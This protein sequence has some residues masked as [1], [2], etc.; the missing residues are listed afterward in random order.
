MQKQT[1]VLAAGALLLL[2]AGAMLAPQ[3]LAED[4]V[5][6]VRW[7]AKD[8]VEV[9]V[10]TLTDAETGNVVS[11]DGIERI[12]AEGE[13]GALSDEARVALIL[14]GRVVNKFQAPVA[15]ATVWLDFGRGGARGGG[16]GNR[17]R[18]VP[19]PVQSD[20]EGRFA[21]Q[22]QT[23]RNLRVSL[24][25]GHGNYAPGLFDKDLGEVTAEV[26][27]GDL[28]LT[29]GGEVIG[30]VTDLEGNGI[31]NA[32][33]DFGPDGGNR[34]GMVRNRENLMPKIVTDN[35]GFYRK[36]H[37][38]A[39]E[40]TASATAKR[41]T[42]GRAPTFVV[43]EDQVVAV[44]DIRLGP[45][46]EVTGYVRTTQGQPIAKAEVT[47]RSINRGGR[48]RG[49]G[50]E[51]GTPGLNAPGTNGQNWGPENWRAM[52]GR[53]Y[54]TETDEQGRFFLEHLPSVPLQIEAR[55]DG[56]LDFDQQPIDPTLGQP[57]NV[58]MQDGLRIAGTVVDAIDNQPVSLFAVRATRVRGL[59]VAGQA[60]LD[61][62]IQDLMTRLRDGNLDEATRGQLRQQVE[63][64]RATANVEF[65]RGGRGDRGG[66]GGPGGRGGNDNNGPGGGRGP[67]RDLGKPEKHPGGTFVVT[68]LQEGVYEVSV[69]SPEHARFRSQEVEV[70]L[71]LSPPTVAANLD[72]GLFVAGVVTSEKGTPVQGATVELRASSFE[73]A[74]GRRGGRGGRGGNEGEA[75]RAVGPPTS[76]GNAT[77]QGFREFQRFAAGTLVTIEATTDADGVFVLKH[78]ARGSYRLQARARGFADASSDTFDLQADRSGVALQLGLLGSVTGKVR[79]LR[80]KETSEAHVAA[81]QISGGQGGFGGMFRGRGGPGGGGP[82]NSV[83][84]QADGTY[85]IDDLAPGDYIVRSWIGGAQDL[86]REMMPQFF[87]NTLTA[88]VK[89]KG[90]EVANFDLTVFRP[91]IGEVAGTVMHNGTAAV[92]FRVE[93]TLVDENGGA[94]QG[95]GGRGGGPGGGRQGG[96]FGGG[97]SFQATVASSGNFAIKDVPAGSYRLRVQPA[98]R[99]GTLHEEMVHVAADATTELNLRVDTASLRGTVT[100][101]DGAN[102]SELNGSVMLLA[103]L[104]AMPENLQA[105]RRDPNNTTFDARVQNGGF[106]FETL[107]PDNY[108]L[109]LT[110]RGRERTSLPVVVVAGSEQPVVVAAGKVA[111]PASGGNAPQSGQPARPNGSTGR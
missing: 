2:S 68:G 78:A 79:G 88:D 13:G 44:E 87:A 107:K 81:M 14:R 92:G 15:D 43:E 74:P 39:G 62:S 64:L 90:G 65:G 3:W 47:M 19:D 75:V 20:K 70:R 41:H 27:L 7:D 69:Q 84:V 80:S 46:F 95:R 54:S 35:N 24:Q 109:V 31:A 104:T 11:A 52:F 48:G 76:A 93:L 72:R 9:D 105:W 29:N 82:F 77:E 55:A 58:V 33:I 101:D 8:E 102:A 17:Q 89:V 97:R 37:V 83:T 73:Q 67:A 30:R 23:F 99:G 50:G 86:M 51:A 26:D 96:P 18:R 45:G 25:V 42:Q 61:A 56:Y 16:P 53:D 40:W 111:A 103:G 5:P 38:L 110:I 59:P 10:A 100:R 60:Q 21:F 57:V 63:G 106:R 36:P 6:L 4:D 71:S 49:P 94:Q 66:N 85:R 108:L 22:G 12:A 28:A 34:M 91:Q 32:S 1:I 98:R